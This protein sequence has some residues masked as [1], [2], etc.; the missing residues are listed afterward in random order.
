MS[1]KSMSQ[2]HKFAAVF[3]P[4]VCLLSF[5]GLGLDLCFADHSYW[6]FQRSGALITLAGIEAQYVKIL[7]QAQGL[8]VAPV[9]WHD[10]LGIPLAIFGTIIWAF[11]DLA[12]VLLRGAS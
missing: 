4:V 2:H 5:T 8:D 11:G 1:W 6:W 3:I 10:K 7:D 12:V 9:S